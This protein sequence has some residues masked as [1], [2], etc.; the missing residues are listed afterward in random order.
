MN[1]VIS[2][3]EVLKV[4]CKVFKQTVPYI[5]ED[6]TETP[7]TMRLQIRYAFNNNPNL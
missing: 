4:D 3:S 5:L 1:Y 6:F 2:S 7:G